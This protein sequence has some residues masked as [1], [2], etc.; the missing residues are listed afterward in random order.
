MYVPMV[1]ACQWVSLSLLVIVFVSWGAADSMLCLCAGCGPGISGQG[2]PWFQWCWP[3][4]DLPEGLQAGHPTCHWGR[5]PLWART[6]SEPRCRHGKSLQWL[7]L[8]AFR[9]LSFLFLSSI[10]IAIQISRK[11]F[12]CCWDCMKMSLIFYDQPSS[13]WLV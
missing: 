13:S 6:C 3:D 2:D 8:S 10:Q 9:E 12:F 11:E 4:R 5:D 7:I 1:C